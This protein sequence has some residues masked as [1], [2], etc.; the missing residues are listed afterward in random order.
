MH[1]GKL[2]AGL[3]AVDGVNP[4]VETS[5][6]LV[7]LPAD[8]LRQ[9]VPR[10][11]G[12]RVAGEPLLQWRELQPRQ[13][14]GHERTRTVDRARLSGRYSSDTPRNLNTWRMTESGVSFIW[15]L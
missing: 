8:R 4:G 11:P 1:M 6:L 14:A 3:A 13:P 9:R 15:V 10:L 7:G 12:V 2:G 5:K